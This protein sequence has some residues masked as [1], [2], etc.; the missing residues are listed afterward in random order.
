MGWTYQKTSGRKTLD[1]IRA[2]IAGEIVASAV[3][4]TESYLAVRDETTGEVSGV[5]VL[6]HRPR[7]EIGIK[8]I[9]EGAGPLYYRAP[10]RV[11]AALTPARDPIALGWRAICRDRLA[12]CEGLKGDLTGRRF[13]IYGKTFRITGRHTTRRRSWAAVGEHNGQFYCIPPGLL[14]EADPAD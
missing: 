2:S 12:R 14:K 10:A 11:L 5:V 13:V 7:G 1:I 6:I 8:I 3:Y 9:S 4:L